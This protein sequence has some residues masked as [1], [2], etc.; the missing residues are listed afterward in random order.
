MS[1]PSDL[2]ALKF[3]SKEFLAA[4]GKCGLLNNEKKSFHLRLPL[5]SFWHNVVRVILHTR[6]GESQERHCASLSVKRIPSTELSARLSSPLERS[7]KCYGLNCE[8]KAFLENSYPLHSQQK[9]YPK[10]NLLNWE[11]NEAYWTLVKKHYW[12]AASDKPLK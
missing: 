8:P 9:I 7:Q 2:P 12:Q 4:W 5:T 3:T 11:E 1:I 6:C 10:K